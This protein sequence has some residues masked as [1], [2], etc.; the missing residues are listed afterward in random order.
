MDEVKWIDLKNAFLGLSDKQWKTLAE[1]EEGI[2]FMQE[3]LYLEED[4]FFGTEGMNK[5]FS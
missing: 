2:D 1:S 3:V 5:R 4:D